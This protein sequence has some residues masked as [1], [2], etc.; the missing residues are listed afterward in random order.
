MFSGA[1]LLA[2]NCTDGTLA[3]SHLAF[4]VTC[5]TA[6]SDGVAIAFSS[7]DNSIYAYGM[8]PTRTTINAPNIGVTTATPIT[9]TG[10][11]TDISAGASQ[12]AVAANYPNGLPCVSDAS[13]SDF[14]EAVYQQQTMP[15]NITG[16]QVTLSVLDGNGNY[17]VIGTTTSN[18]LGDYSFTWTPDISGSYTVYATFAGT[19]SYYGSSAS[20]GLY[21]SEPAATSTPQLTQ[22]PSAA[23]LYFLPAIVGLFV[24]II[25]CIAMITL[26]LKKNP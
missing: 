15:Y 14:M 12:E 20:T 18:T 9:L 13:M 17:R 23:D 4:D 3:W 24:A 5:G 22:A 19:N 1:Q 25:V 16:V 6:V 8:G 7:Y 11:I 26:V 10:T 21:A 2:I